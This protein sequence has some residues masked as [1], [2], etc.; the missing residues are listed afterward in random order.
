MIDL[1]S[2]AKVQMRKKIR[3]LRSVEQAALAEID[4]PQS[5][6]SSLNLTQRRAATQIVLDYCAAVRGVL[7]DN[8][9]GPLRPAGWRM[10]GALEAIGQSLERNLRQPPT[11]IRPQLA[12]L[13]GNLQRGLT[14]YAQDKPRIASYLATVQQIWNTLCPEQGT[15]D[16]RLTTFRQFCQ[17][18][19]GTDDPI[20]RHRSQ[21]MQSFEAGLFVGSPER[22]L[23]LDNLDLERWIRAPKGHERRIH[24]RQHV[25]RRMIVEGATLLPALDAHIRRTE[26]FMVHDVLPYVHVEVPASQQ[27]AVTRHRMMTQARSKKTARTS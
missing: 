13:Q 8:H 20:T 24:G 2:H 18:L 21:V 5:M 25:G 3:G 23:P 7:N 1:D 11:P 14:L 16:A 10:A 4:Q 15:R 26:P 27:Q 9:G 6:P 22:D 12:Q 17:Q 19:A